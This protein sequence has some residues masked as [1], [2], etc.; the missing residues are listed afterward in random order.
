MTVSLAVQM[1]PMWRPGRVGEATFEGDL[2]QLAEGLTHYFVTQLE[3]FGDQRGADLYVG[4]SVKRG[5]ETAGHEYRSGHL[6]EAAQRG[7]REE[8]LMPN[9]DALLI[10]GPYDE[11][12]IIRIGRARHGTLYA[13]P[14]VAQPE[15][16]LGRRLADAIREE[17]SDVDPVTIGRVIVNTASKAGATLHAGLSAPMLL[18]VLADAAFRLLGDYTGPPSG[19]G[20][21]RESGVSTYSCVCA[22][23]SGES[24]LSIVDAD[25]QAAEHADLP[26]HEAMIDVTEDETEPEDYP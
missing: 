11:A 17:L 24:G 23:G 3:R 14:T 19:G 6:C 20:R 13:D 1:G 4:L 2:Y 12:E 15:Q 10:S 18:N 8:H 21:G 16:W 7:R 9:P 5:E 22:C 25:Q 26:N